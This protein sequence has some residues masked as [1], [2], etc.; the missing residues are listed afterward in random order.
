MHHLITGPARPLDT[1]VMP[2]I[3][4]GP[5]K[6]FRSWCRAHGADPAEQILG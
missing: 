4:T 2:W 6:S 1:H 3:A 5:G